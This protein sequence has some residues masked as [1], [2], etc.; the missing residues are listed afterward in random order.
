MR[1]ITEGGYYRGDSKVIG[2]KNINYLKNLEELTG[3]G[4]LFLNRRNMM[5]FIINLSQIAN[6]VHLSVLFTEPRKRRDFS[7]YS[8]LGRESP[9][10][11]RTAQRKIYGIEFMSAI[12]L[13][14]KDRRR[15][16]SVTVE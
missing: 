13:K 6:L 14:S 2:N 15:V 12:V 7:A 8:L 4:I 3:I 1:N 5:L 10:D 9:G 16:S 11:F